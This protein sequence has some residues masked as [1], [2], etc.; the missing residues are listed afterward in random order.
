[1]CFLI[2]V[3]FLP[4]CELAEQLNLF[5]NFYLAKVAINGTWV[6]DNWLSPPWGIDLPAWPLHSRIRCLCVPGKN[7]P[8]KRQKSLADHLTSDTAT[9]SERHHRLRENGPSLRCG[10]VIHYKS[11]YSMGGWTHSRG[12]ACLCL[13]L[14]WLHTR[15]WRAESKSRGHGKK[16]RKAIMS[17]GVA[18]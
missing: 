4:S 7:S 15:G 1:M 17:K 5:A 9:A 18:I 10:I 16:S 3:N 12:E 2:S 14:F 8:H 6:W 13:S 11:I